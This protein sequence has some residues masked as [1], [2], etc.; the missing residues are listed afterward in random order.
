M[1]GGF[2]LAVKV[3]RGIIRKIGIRGSLMLATALAT[4]GFT[5]LIFAI[6]PAPPEWCQAILPVLGFAAGLL[7]TSVFELIAPAYERAPGA[8]LSL[9]GIVFVAG[10][11]VATLISASA[12]EGYSLW[13]PL[14]FFAVI[15]AAYFFKFSTRPATDLP[16]PSEN[17]PSATAELWSPGAILLTLVFFFQFGN[18]WAIAGW[19]PLFLIQRLGISPF[20]ALLFLALYWLA[21]L[22]GRA[23]IQSILPRFRQF[24]VLMASAVSALFGC[25][26]LALTNNRFGATVAILLI[27]GGFAAIYPL[28]V[29]MTGRRFKSYHPV[30]FNGIFSLGLA[31]GMLTPWLIGLLSHAAGIGRAMLIPL[32]GTVMVFLILLLIRLEIKLNPID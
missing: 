24:R 3:S 17:P 30:Y 32:G 12:I 22:I 26:I 6:P 18:E 2:L 28:L 13:L 29:D 7:N 8:T 10:S 31:G 4:C 11:L 15:A 16:A 23:L 5:G 1:N 27:G 20:G 21:L 19:L 14:A 9:G 25:T